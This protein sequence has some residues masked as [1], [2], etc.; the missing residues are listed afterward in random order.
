MDLGRGV[1]GKERP[2]MDGKRRT[3]A[4]LAVE[5][6]EG[7]SI[8]PAKMGI[9]QRIIRKFSVMF[10]SIRFTVNIGVSEQKQERPVS[11]AFK[12]RS[13]SG[14]LRRKLTKNSRAIA[15]QVH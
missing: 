6:G 2:R 13:L 5:A 9:H 12:G 3:L 15:A 11:E 14:A 7:R 10:D 4:R 8:L 1:A